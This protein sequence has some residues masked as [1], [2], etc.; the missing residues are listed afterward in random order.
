[1]IAGMGTECRE[2]R[3]GLPHCHG[4]LIHHS[5]QPTQCTEPGC[6]HPEVLLHSLAVDCQAIGCECDERGGHLV[7]I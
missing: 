2:C 1:M 5:C 4:T 6:S 3:A 7:A